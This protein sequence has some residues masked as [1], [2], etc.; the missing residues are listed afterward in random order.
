MRH[1]AVIFL[2]SRF[3]IAKNNTKNPRRRNRRGYVFLLRYL[4]FLTVKGKAVK[5]NYPRRYAQIIKKFI[6]QSPHGG[7]AVFVVFACSLSRKDISMP[8]KKDEKQGKKYRAAAAASVGTGVCRHGCL[9]VRTFIGAHPRR[10]AFS[11]RF[12]PF[13]RSCLW[14]ACVPCLSFRTSDR[15]LP[16]RRKGCDCRGRGE[17]R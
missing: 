4:L 9:S 7:V 12:G 5:G 8:A 3:C 10:S 11:R 2:L 14:A 15:A 1:G 13:C 6:K 17:G 16:P